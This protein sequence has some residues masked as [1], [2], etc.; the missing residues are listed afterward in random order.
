MSPI[1]LPKLCHSHAVLKDK[2]G[3]SEGAAFPLHLLQEFL[4]CTFVQKGSA[5]GRVWAGAGSFLNLRWALIQEW[6][7]VWKAVELFSIS[8]FARTLERV[9]WAEVF[10]CC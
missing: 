3:A 10:S 6:C 5:E 7:S 1:S 9:F 8:S 4:W 2:R